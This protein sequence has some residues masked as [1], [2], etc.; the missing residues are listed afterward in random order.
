L[1]DFHDGGLD[2]G[3]DTLTSLA[4][5]RRKSWP[6]T[7]RFVWLIDQFEELFNS[8]LKDAT[9]DAFGGF[10]SRLQAD[11]VWVL[12]SIRA[13]AMPKLKEYESLRKIF[14]ANEG[15]YY[16]G[17]LNGPA[18]DEVIERPAIAADLTFGKGIDGKPLDQLLREDTYHE[19]DSLPLLQFTLNELYLA[20]SANELTCASYERLGGIAGSIATAAQ[21][22]LNS[23]TEPRQSIP[24]LFRS[25]VTVDE[26]GRATRR[27]A[28]LSDIA[29]DPVQYRLLSRL[30]AARLCV[31]D[32]RDGQ[33]IVAFAH[34]TLL[35]SL[36]PLTDWLSREVVLLQTREMA[37]RDTR[38]WQKHGES[39]AWLAPADKLIAFKALDEAAI[40]LPP[41]LKV[42]IS[43]SRRRARR[44]TLIKQAVLACIV[45]LAIAATTF[46]VRFK[47]ERDSAIHSERRA[48]IEARTASDTSDFLVKL[49]KV[50][51]PGESRGNTIT[52]RE[53]LDRGAQQIQS[54]LLAQP[55]VKARLMRTMGEVYG[56]LGLYRDSHRLIKDALGEVSRPGVADEI[57]V[58]RAKKAMGEALVGLE[59]YK[60]AEPFL[61]E[62]MGEFDRH[63]D[64]AGESALVRDDLGFLFWSAQDYG[65][66]RPILEDA[67]RRANTNFGHQSGEVAGILSNLGI[68]VRDLG[69]PSNGLHLLEES[70]DIYK[71]MFGEDYALYAMGRESVGFTLIRLGK[72]EEAKANL[73]AGVAIQERVLGPNHD[74]LAEGLQGLGYAETA[75]GQFSDADKTL[76]RALAIEEKALGPDSK[77]VGRTE[78]NLAGV[79]VGEKKFD[80]AIQ[81]NK[82]AA[83]IARVALGEES[84]DYITALVNL[85][86]TQRRAGELSDAGATL[87]QALAIAERDQG[88][89]SI[90]LVTVLNALA[91][92]LCFRHPDAEGLA[93]AQ[94]AINVH[95]TVYPLQLA[96]VK[97]V[98]AYCDPD[99]TH[100]K[101]N[102]QQLR[103]VQQAIQK[104]RGL[105]SLQEEDVNRRIKR[106]HKTWDKI[107]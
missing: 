29:S 99:P 37:Q 36:P 53:I 90:G 4:E 21:L 100:A 33:P 63:P 8:G 22:V 19:R 1:P 91:D 10:L 9:I 59:D 62:A 73:E 103:D 58:A 61:V 81:A 92:I 84:P 23:E 27:Y 88:D 101:Q 3:S 71:R 67:L 75:L 26:G 93:L 96:I 107:T 80:K 5:S 12:A 74:I 78:S 97:S 106:F 85:G 28:P 43:C 64:Q 83:L 54:Q 105:S 39:D 82:R 48:E 16:L 17:T 35:H 79:Y 51:D 77:E 13:D 18:L 49:F 86:M 98:A 2:D 55:V 87:R 45:A 60:G 94:R 32:Q 72:Y 14:G 52:A 47:Y 31:T 44:E 38:E 65:H 20:R 30:I 46:G 56:G 89:P 95:R 41:P 34:D 68:A 57:E 7:N 15:Q 76:N 11:G 70:N 6:A 102:E 104:E 69:D 25:L 24:R 40:F 50:V 42:Y 66:A